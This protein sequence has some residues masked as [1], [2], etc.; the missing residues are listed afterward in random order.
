MP[1]SP[2]G[3]PHTLPMHLL[4]Y[5]RQQPAATARKGRGLAHGAW[6]WQAE[7]DYWR[8]YQLHSSVDILIDS[9]QASPLQT[10]SQLPR[11]V[12]S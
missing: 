10:A 9:Q 8:F 6:S 2:F 12:R 7:V 4:E 3:L 11:N 5:F 1:A